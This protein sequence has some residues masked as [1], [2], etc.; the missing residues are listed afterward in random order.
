MSFPRRH[1][2]GGEDLVLEDKPLYALGEPEE[3]EEDADVLNPGVFDGLPEA[4]AIGGRRLRRLNGNRI[5]NIETKI[6]KP[7][8][9]RLP[10]DTR[11]RP[12]P[13]SQRD[14]NGSCCF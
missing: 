9:P 2:H 6:C 5:L 8:H 13:I 10:V 12:R 7:L 14:M 3:G 4:G 1:R 11:R